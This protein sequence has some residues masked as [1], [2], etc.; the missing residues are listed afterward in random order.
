MKNLRKVLIGAAFMVL[1]TT[2][3]AQFHWGMKLGF[4]ASKMEGLQDDKLDVSFMP[5]FHLGFAFQYILPVQVGFETGVYFSGMGGAT[6]REESANGYFSSEEENMSPY[7]VQ[8]P[9]SV[10]YK[11]NIGRNT[12]LIPSIGGYAGYGVYGIWSKTYKVTSDGRTILNCSPDRFFFGKESGREFTGDNRRLDSNNPLD[13]G[14]T[15]GLTFLYKKLT[16]GFAY[17]H[18]LIKVNKDTRH[19]V[20]IEDFSEIGINSTSKGKEL[21]DLYNRNFKI[22]IG[23][24]FK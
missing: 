12:S 20:I 3:N 21:K 23:Y 19:E 16:V 18:G 1:A 9:L 6:K 11:I 8:V 4:N 2:A 13:M 10:L 5:G 24:F 15:A 14:A 17:E 7:Y 22:S